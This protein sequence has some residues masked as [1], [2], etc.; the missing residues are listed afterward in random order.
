MNEA[1]RIE[2]ARRF[3]EAKIETDFSYPFQVTYE[4][5]HFMFTLKNGRT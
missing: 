2:S 1:E 4:D 5:G 3:L